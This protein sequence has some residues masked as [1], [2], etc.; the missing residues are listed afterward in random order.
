MKALLQRVTQAS[1]E[2]DG[3][4]VGRIGDG[5]LA[6]VGCRRGD[7]PADCDDLSRR[8]PA[9]RVFTD[10]TGRMNR[11]LLDTRGSILVVS[12]F[13]LYADTRRG[14]RPGFDLAGDPAEAEALVRRFVQSLRET[15]GAHRVATGVFAASMRVA[16]LNDGPVTIEL[17]SDHKR[18]GHAPAPDTAP[19]DA[20]C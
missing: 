9:L 19:G 2:V 20:P 16:L 11:S 13:T 10:E 6:L 12:Q 8:V 3:V 4:E 1:V 14:H 18:L 7:T 17:S 5:L 15:L